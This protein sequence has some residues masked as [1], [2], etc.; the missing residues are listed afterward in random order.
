M[1]KLMSL[2]L[3]CF[4]S[5]GF[6]EENLIRNGNFAEEGLY[7]HVRLHDHYGI[8]P[9]VSYVEG[10]VQLSGLQPSTAPYLGF[11]QAVEIQEG[12]KYKLSFD[13]K[14]EGEG[15]AVLRLGSI[16]AGKN[17]SEKTKEN[18]F[19]K[20]ALKSAGEW[21]SFEYEFTGVYDTHRKFVKTWDELMG[22]DKKRR[23]KDNPFE[24]YSPGTG[25]VFALGKVKGTVSLKNISL[26]EVAE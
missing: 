16:T 23:K 21:T 2:C 6:A 13:L 10:A 7:W 12:V 11:V 19:I 3:V 25:I 20:G 8:T 26:T 18:H 4:T 24:K 15:A 5:I 1:K 22:E 17:N 9:N 14:I